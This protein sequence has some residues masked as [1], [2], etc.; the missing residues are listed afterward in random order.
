MPSPKRWHPVSRDLNDDAELWA[1]TEEFGDRAIR[2]WLEVL[3]IL[4]R[5]EN[6]WRLNGDWL[7]TISRKVRLYPKKVSASVLWMTKKGWL[8]VKEQD[9]DGSPLVLESPNY[10]KY[11]KRRDAKAEM[12]GADKGTIMAPSYPNL[13]FPNH[14]NR[15]EEKEILR[16]GSSEQERGRGRNA[17][18]RAMR[19]E[20]LP[21]HLREV[22]EFSPL[23]S[24]LKEICRRLH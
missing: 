21:P 11:H 10:W 12:E 7:G 6:H 19:E 8:S 13:P 18:G 15:K 5:T 22:E 9:S 17:V 1:F 3:A 4:D 2:I 23:G 14:P 24:T 16:S 20:D